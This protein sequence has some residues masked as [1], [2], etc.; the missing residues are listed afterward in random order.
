MVRAKNV[1]FQTDDIAILV[2]HL[3]FKTP[4][5]TQNSS[6][7]VSNQYPHIGQVKNGFEDFRQFLTS[8]D[9]QLRNDGTLNNVIIQALKAHIDVNEH[10]F[11]WH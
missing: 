11:V 4:I 8:S 5:T 9:R 10:G 1:G 6:I 2:P 7:L 3:L